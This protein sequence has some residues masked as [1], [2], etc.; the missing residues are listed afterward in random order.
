MFSV[1]YILAFINSLCYSV[2]N[3]SLSQH[4]KQNAY[5]LKNK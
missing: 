3:N 5:K 4:L 1:T 2:F